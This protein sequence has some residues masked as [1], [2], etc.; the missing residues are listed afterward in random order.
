MGSKIGLL[1]IL[2]EEVSEMNN[3]F[4]IKN[5]PFRIDNLEDELNRHFV[6]LHK[7]L[8]SQPLNYGIKGE[9][10]ACISLNCD[11]T[12]RVSKIMPAHNGASVPKVAHVLVEAETSLE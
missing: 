8:N 1:K 5:Q 6:I 7:G 3:N 4:T 11:I 2:L 10:R 12:H 9:N